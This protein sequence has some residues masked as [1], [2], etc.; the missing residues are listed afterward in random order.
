MKQ[1]TIHL[2]DYRDPECP[3]DE[4]TNPESEMDAYEEACDRECDARREALDE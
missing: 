1:P 3:Y 4:S 2:Y